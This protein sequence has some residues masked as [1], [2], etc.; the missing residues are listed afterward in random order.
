MLIFIVLAALMLAVALAFVLMP[1]LRGPR[2][3]TSHEARRL[4]AL[5]EQSHRSGILSDAEYAAKRNALGERLLGS[6]DAPATPRR[7]YAAA[8]AIA[9]ILP[10]ASIVLYRLVGTPAAF[11]PDLQSAEQ[12]PA[13]HGADMQQAIDK[14]AA[15]LKQNP[16]DAEGWTLLGR[17]YEATQRFGEARDALKHAY[18]LAKGDPDVAVAYAEALALSS[19]TRRIEGESRQILDAALKAAPD[20][21][22]GLWLLGISEY[23][24]KKYDSAIAAWN[25]LIGGLPKDSDIIASVQQQIAR[26]QAERDGKP[27]PADDAE[28]ASAAPTESAQTPATAAVNPQLHVEVALDPKLRDKLA[29][30]DV[31]FVYAKAA[32][33]PPMPLA[34]QRMEADKLPVTVVLT[35]GMGMLPNMKLSQFPQV[36]IGARVSK[37]GTAMPQSGD[38]QVLSKPISVTTTQPIKLTIDQ[39]V[40]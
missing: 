23:Q 3:T 1:L 11:A 15:K 38:L 26:A 37:S 5:L 40:P 19:P 31:L 29:S 12:A 22:R 14:L 27:L 9:L 35:D 4:L 2:G 30:G 24:A 7:G 10:A 8:I 28:S 17:A 36:V 13:D 32:S 6:L 33:G 21:Q 39:I 16:D 25:R 34:I 20:N 18:D